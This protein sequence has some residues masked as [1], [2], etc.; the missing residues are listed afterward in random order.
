MRPQLNNN[1]SNA[2]FLLAFTGILAL[3]VLPLTIIYI[4]AIARAGQDLAGIY[5]KCGNA[6]Y[7]FVIA[8]CAFNWLLAIAL[9]LGFV[10]LWTFFLHYNINNVAR[11]YEVL[12]GMI[13]GAISVVYSMLSIAALAIVPVAMSA[14]QCSQAISKVSWGQ[15]WLGIVGH[16]NL[17]IDL[18]IVLF[19]GSLSCMIFS[20]KNDYHA[21]SHTEAVVDAPRPPLPPMEAAEAK[22]HEHSSTIVNAVKSMADRLEHT[23]EKYLSR[24]DSETKTDPKVDDRGMLRRLSRDGGPELS[25]SFLAAEAHFNGAVGAGGI[26]ART[27][28]MYASDN[29]RHGT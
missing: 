28:L 9:A 19:C 8:N 11:Q 18:C 4:L 12:V 13:L 1:T 23:M 15:P 27:P 7:P 24:A 21:P 10:W 14:Q 5:S 29:S 25:R 3:C 22:N 20:P 17:A 6:F 26:G 16:M 2:G